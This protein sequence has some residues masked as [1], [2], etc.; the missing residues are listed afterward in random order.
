M[1]DFTPEMLAQIETMITSAIAYERSLMT[2]A[3]DVK[4]GNLTK[5]INESKSK[6]IEAYVKVNDRITKELAEISAKQAELASKQAELSMRISTFMAPPTLPPPPPP[7]KLAVNK[8]RLATIP[9]L[10]EDEDEEDDWQSIYSSIEN[11]YNKPFVVPTVPAAST[12]TV[13]AA[14]TTTSTRPTPIPIPAKADDT[15][16]KNEKQIKEIDRQITELRNRIP[17]S[18][19]N[20][21][22]GVYLINGEY[23]TDMK[24]FGLDS[25]KFNM[26]AIENLFRNLG[27]PSDQ[28]STWLSNVAS[29][30]LTLKQIAA[31]NNTKADLIATARKSIYKE[32]YFKK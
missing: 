9:E 15:D 20:H 2:R 16:D 13:P 32:S 23:Y 22:C 18:M 5:K 30:Q 4:I 12:T 1:T 31:L 11:H 19:Y 17:P 27:I 7:I 8:P 24:D 28:M 10:N 14:S 3:I 25:L 29:I 26:P 21:D 6:S